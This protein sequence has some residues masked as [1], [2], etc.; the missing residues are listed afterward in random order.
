MKTEDVIL[1]SD[2]LKRR[3]QA[4][5]KIS[6]PEYFINKKNLTELIRRKMIYLLNRLQ[7]EKMQETKH[8]KI[9]TNT[10]AVNI[11]SWVRPQDF[12]TIDIV[13]AIKFN[14]I[15]AFIELSGFN[16]QQCNVI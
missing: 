4:K 12:H 6:S 5:K 11:H 9:G 14:A 10:H 8:W 7:I 2:G 13:E 16:S 15:K 3:K 1:C